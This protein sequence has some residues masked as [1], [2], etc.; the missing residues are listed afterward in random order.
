VLAPLKSCHP[1]SKALLCTIG[2][3]FRLR[4]KFAI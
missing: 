4:G 1:A 2:D 3:S